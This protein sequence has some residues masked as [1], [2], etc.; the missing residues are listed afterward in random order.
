V[1]NKNAEDF[2]QN[3]V[4][5]RQKAEDVMRMVQIRITLYF[6]RKHKPIILERQVY[7]KMMQGP[8]KIGYKIPESTCL[9][10]IKIKPFKI[11]EKIN[12]L[13][14]RLDLPEK[15]KIHSIISVIHLKQAPADKFNREILKPGPKIVKSEKRYEINKIINRK[16]LKRKKSKKKKIWYYLVKWTN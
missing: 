15:L 9:S 4:R 11:I 3:R 13:T 14:Y 10:P 5:I 2:I 16:L 12:S 6:D 1:E 7:I 8:R